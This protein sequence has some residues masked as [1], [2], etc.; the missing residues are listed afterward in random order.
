MDYL[1]EEYQ[2]D[3]PKDEQPKEAMEEGAEEKDG[4]LA[5]SKQQRHAGSVGAEP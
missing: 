2:L 1:D 4:L 5:E 3:K